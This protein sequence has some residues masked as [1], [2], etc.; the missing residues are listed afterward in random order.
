MIDFRKRPRWY[1]SIPILD[2][3]SSLPSLLTGLSSALAPDLGLG[4]APPLRERLLFPS[5]L[6]G[7]WSSSSVGHS[8]HTYVKVR[9]HVSSC[10]LM[11]TLPSPSLAM[12]GENYLHPEGPQLDSSM[13]EVASSNM[14]SSMYPSASWGS[15]SQQSE[16]YSAHCPMQSGN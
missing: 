3:P 6:E 2:L 15:F 13:F 1:P 9:G 7:W 14:E 4:L 12:D 10:S 5:C 8:Q 11:P 16:G